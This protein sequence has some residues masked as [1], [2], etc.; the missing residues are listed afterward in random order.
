MKADHGLTLTHDDDGWD[1]AEC[2][3]GWASPPVPGTDIAAEVW[4][5]HRDTIEE[6][7]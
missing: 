6:K 2:A 3:C 1:I 4:A 7:D 5:D